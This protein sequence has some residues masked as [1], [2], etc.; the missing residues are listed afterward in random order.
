MTAR[1]RE[2]S[3]IA[4]VMPVLRRYLGALA[5]DAQHVLVVC[6]E[7]GRILWLE[8]H[9][10]VKEDAVERIRFSEGML[11]TEGSVGTNAIGTALAIDHAVQ[12]FSA[13]HFLAEHHQPCCSASWT[14]VGRCG[15]RSPARGC[16]DARSAAAH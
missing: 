13:E 6:D 4:G 11:W 14:S 12:V 10:R 15:P 7:A 2:D 16:A 1:G 8:G 5:D 9:E 3:A